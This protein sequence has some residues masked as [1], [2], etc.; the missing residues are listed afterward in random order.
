MER[1][2]NAENL[3]LSLEN[4][5]LTAVVGFLVC[6]SFAQVILRQFFGGGLLWADT[7]NRHLVLW[8]GFLGAAAASA[9]EKQFAFEA[10]TDRLPHSWRGAAVALARG[11]AVAVALILARASWSFM[12][13]ERLADHDLFAIGRI[14]VPGWPFAAILPVGFGLVAA[15]TALRAVLGKI[16]EDGPPH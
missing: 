3:L 13:D 6:T 8:A 1:L 16:P 10:I 5:L 15:H 14:S 11:A 9:H 12:L 7:L 4:A 2:R